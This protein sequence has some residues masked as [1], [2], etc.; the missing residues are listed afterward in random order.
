MYSSIDRCIDRS[1]D[2]CIDKNID[3]SIDYNMIGFDSEF[4]LD[5]YDDEAGTRIDRLISERVTDLSRSYIQKL[6][7]EGYIKVNRNS[8]KINYKVS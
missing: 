6:I 2:K 5:I 7:K 1:M 3:K 8:I 4:L